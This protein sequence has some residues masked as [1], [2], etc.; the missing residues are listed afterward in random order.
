[1]LT[2]PQNAGTNTLK[3]PFTLF[4]KHTIITLIITI[5]LTKTQYNFR[6]EEKSWQ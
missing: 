5:T 4:H 3:E 1:M 6:V 2:T